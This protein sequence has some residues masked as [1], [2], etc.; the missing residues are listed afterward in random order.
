M[1]LRQNKVAAVVGK[2]TSTTFAESTVSTTA[3]PFK[4]A[5]Q[6]Y[7]QKL[8]TH[9]ILTKGLTAGTIGALGDILCQ[10]YV[11]RP[12]K[13]RV[14][15]KEGKEIPTTALWWVDPNRSA[16]FFA[17]GVVVVGPWCHACE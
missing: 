13:E 6:W 15:M 14:L 8:E 3:N 1:L 12:E 10:K 11:D 4:R 2:R 5:F 7:S 17:V 16:R 9:P